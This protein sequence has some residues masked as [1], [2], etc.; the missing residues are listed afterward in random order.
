MKNSLYRGLTALT[1]STALLGLTTSC[2]KDLDQTPKFELTPDKVY[3][4]LN[5]YKQ[6]LAKLYGGFALTG[7]S[8]PGSGDI[9]GIDAGTSDYIR[10]YWSAQELTTDE[11]VIAWNDPGVQE[12]HNMN[13]DANG[14]LLRGLYNRSYYEIA[15]CNEFIR[16]ATDDKLSS[17]LGS[18]EQAQGK[19]FRA[20][21]RFLRAVAYSHII[22]LFGNG[23]FVTENDAVGASR[24]PYYTRKQL[25][26]YV[27][28]ELQ[29]IST[30][31]APARTNEYGRVDQAAAHGYLARMYLN[32]G[33]YTGTPE[34]AKAAEEAKKVIDSGYSLSTTASAASSAYGRNFLADN[35]LPPAANEIIW[36]VIFDITRVQSFGGTTFLVNGATSGADGAWQRYVGQSTGWGGLRTTSA[37]VE[38]F[39]LAGG[40]T[41]RD[42]RGRFWAP[43]QTLAIS[44][45]SQ[46]TQGLGVIKYRNI[47]S[48]GT[49]LGGSLNFSG[50]DFPMLRLSD[51]MLIYA[52]AAARGNADRAIALGYVNQ[53]RARAFRNA[54]GSAIT[55]AQMTPEFILDERARELHWEATRRTDLIRYNRFV[56]A[57]YLWPWKGGVAAGRAVEPFRTI[58]PIPSSDL[59]ANSNLRQN[60]GY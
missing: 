21:A 12:W 43:G 29:A 13:W 14:P 47:T 23:P 50:V 57:T 37:L 7:P 53:I 56:E 38:K 31:L 49:G 2:M 52:E 11:A 10:Q 3:V 25:Y 6:V 18:G 26:D 42:T 15:I 48:N 19:L 16:E 22:D 4:D 28:S 51:M 9:R 5:G 41:V 54:A 33:V 39:F 30:E 35:N 45:L 55:N 60:P 17:R 24:P 27:V 32:A 59:T 20:E 58:F 36:P 8:G 1:L 46:F 44:D 34:F 40:D